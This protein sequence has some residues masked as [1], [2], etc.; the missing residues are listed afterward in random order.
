MSI[1]LVV[2]G[3][4]G[5]APRDELPERAAAVA[6]A[7]AAGWQEIGAGALAAATAAVRWMEDEPILNAGLGACLNRDGAAELDAGV[8]AGATLSA[9]AVGAVQDVRHP[10]DLAHRVMEDGRH[11]LLVAGGASQFARE[12]GLEMCENSLFV[13]P[14]A[15]ERW[16]ARLSDTVGAVAADGEG[17]VAV[18]VS[19][20]GVEGKL[21]GRVGDSPI[22]GAG[23]YADDRLGAACGTGRGEDFMRISICRQ[24]VH[25]LAGSSAQAA[26]D[27]AIGQLVEI[28]GMG[29]VIV[30]SPAGEVGVAFNTKSMA[31]AKQVG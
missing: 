20:G 23:F 12:A 10:V 24:A 6:R 29:G 15:R 7:L 1:A 2:H 16:R 8:M 13:T 21:P 4:A 25:L 30:V 9:G 31:W 3:G 18:A 28:G 17:H 11:V 14:R 26:A 5:A 22:P 27:A 19:T